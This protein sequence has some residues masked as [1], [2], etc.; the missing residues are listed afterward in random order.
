LPASVRNRLA[1][2]GRAEEAVTAAA[3]ARKQ[4]MD[5]FDHSELAK[6]MGTESGDVVRQ[7]GSVF[8]SRDAVSRMQEL[9][10][11]ANGNPAAKA[12]LRRAV[13]EHIQSQFL[14]NT[15]AGTTGASQIKADAFQTF[16]RTKQDVLA[17]VFKPEE[18]GALRAVA[19]DLQRANR[20]INATKLAGGSN[21]AQDT[22]HRAA[23]DGTILN[24]IAID[25]AIGVAAHVATNSAS[26]G[27]AG[28]LGA[29]TVSALRD[30]GIS[31]VD[32]LV[33]EAMLNPELARTL[34]QKVPAPSDKG[35]IERIVRAAKQITV[36]GPAIGA[37]QQ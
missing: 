33:K 8:N 3:A 11:A 32:D 22:A 36:A 19:Q 4:R 29:R 9:A 2:P 10:T 26:G 21:T 17:K 31:Q 23:M 14:S 12:G 35:A 30:A 18:I 1:N 6:V 28:W 5:T 27:L 25:A 34:L 37:T 13:V 7:I 16:M 15:E 24:K 20:T